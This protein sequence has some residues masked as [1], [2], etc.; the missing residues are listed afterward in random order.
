MADGSRE[1]VPL[2]RLARPLLQDFVYVAARMRIDEREQFVA[3]AGTSDY[4]ADLCARAGA[5]T[6]GAHYAYVDRAG[7]PVLLGGFEP[8]RPGVY[9]GW[10]MATEGGWQKYGP[11]FHRLCIRLMD[12]VFASGAHRIQTCALESRTQAHRW[13]ERIGMA[14]EGVLAGYCTNGHSGVM[15]ARTKA[16]S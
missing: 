12:D 10:H 15:F 9:E 7:Y 4:D 13:Y 16:K 2:L 11:L 1:V 3:M 8:L 5:N 14:R 6:P